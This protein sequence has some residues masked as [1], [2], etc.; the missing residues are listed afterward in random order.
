MEGGLISQGIEEAKIKEVLADF[1]DVALPAFV[2]TKGDIYPEK[3][4]IIAITLQK[5]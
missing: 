4:K 2:A 5:K 3:Y 1:F